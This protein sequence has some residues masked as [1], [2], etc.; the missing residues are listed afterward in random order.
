MLW[1]V[2]NRH[3]IP[4]FAKVERKLA[5]LKAKQD[6]VEAAA[7]AAQ[8][9]MEGNTGPEQV[10]LLSSSFLN[11]LVWFGFGFSVLARV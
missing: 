3:L 7:G 10:G 5:A 8:Q 11:F 4:G 2:L 1:L 6:S 9:A